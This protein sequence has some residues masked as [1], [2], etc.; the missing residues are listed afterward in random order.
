M[1][2]FCDEVAVRCPW[3]YGNKYFEYL[4]EGVTVSQEKEESWE[5]FSTPKEKLPPQPNEVE[6]IRAEPRERTPPPGRIG[7]PQSHRPALL[8]LS[9]LYP[10]VP[11]LCDAVRTET[12]AKKEPNRWLASGEADAGDTEILWLAMAL[13]FKGFPTV[14]EQKEWYKKVLLDETRAREQR[15][16]WKP[17]STGDG[18]WPLKGKSSTLFEPIERALKCCTWTHSDYE[19]IGTAIQLWDGPGQHD[20]LGKTQLDSYIHKPPLG[21]RL[22]KKTAPPVRWR[23][24]SVVKVAAMMKEHGV[25]LR[26]ALKLDVDPLTAPTSWDRIAAAEERASTAEKELQE[27]Q[28]ATAKLVD[29]HRKLKDASKKKH[30]SVLRAEE[31]AKLLQQQKEAKSALLSSLRE[32]N[33]AALALKEQRMEEKYNDKFEVQRKGLNKARERAREAEHEKQK[34]E[35]KVRRLQKKIDE[36]EEEPDS[37]VSE[38]EEDDQ[39]D[40]EETPSRAPRLEL[41]PR[42]DERGRWQ[43]EDW[44][45][46]ALRWAQQARGVAPSTVSRN[47][48]DVLSLIAPELEVPATCERQ[49]KI[50]RGEV[51][52]GGEAMAA[53]KFAKATRILSFGWD[54]S[55]KF[56]DSVFSCNAQVQHG[57]GT[58]EDICLRGLSILPEGGKSA[59][60]LAHIEKRIF[61]Y[62]RRILMLWKDEYEKSMGAGTWAMA[63]GADPENIGLHRLC[64][65]TV[66][67]TD[68][69]NGAR[70]TKRM[71]AEA[72]MESIKAKVGL[73]AWE[74]M[75]EEERSRKY[76]V[77][78]GDCWQHLRNI[79][80][81]AMAQAGDKHVK[82]A[83][84]DSLAEFSSF[85]RIE[86]EGSSVIRGIFKQ[87]H[88]GGEYCKGR[89]REFEVD[90]KRKHQ[91]SLFI[92]FERAMGSRQD[93]KFDGCVPLFWN[94][95]ICLEFLRGYISCPKSENVLDK[96]LYTIL[97]CNEF[98]A[99]LRAN[100]LWD[101]LFSRPFRWLSGRGSKLE[102]WSIF[103]MS[104]V[105]DRVESVMMEI[106]E[107]PSRLLDPELDIFQ[108][109]ADE[110]PEFKDWRTEMMATKVLAEDGHTE[111]YLFREILKEARTPKA[112][113][114]NAQATPMTLEI[115]RAQAARAVEKLHDKKIALADKLVSQDGVNSFGRNQDGHERTKKAHVSNDSVENKFAT[116]DYFMRTYRHASIHN[117]SGLVQQRT[118]HDLDRPL[119]IVSD[120]RKRKATPPSEDE[121]VP[122]GFFWNNLDDNLRRALVSMARHELAY[123]LK[124]GREERRQHDEEKLA[125]REES[126]Q[127]QLNATIEKYAAALELFD[128]WKTQGV[129]NRDQLNERLQGLTISDQLAELRR[130][131]EMRTVGCGWVQFA[132]KWSF[133]AD[134][135]SATLEQ[136]KQLLVDD[137]LPH[138]T[139]LRRQK[140]LPASAAPPQLTARLVKTL[141]TAD[142][143]AARLEAAGLFNTSN[144]LARAEAAR[145]RREAQGISDSVEVK[146]PPTA[147][148]FDTNLVGKRLEVCWPYKEN[149]GTTVKIWASGTVKRVADGLTDKRSSRAREVLPAGALLWAW[150]E[151]KEFDEPAGEKWLVLLPC[152]WNKHV[153]YAWR[154]DPC[155]LSTTGGR[156]TPPREPI[157]DPY[158][159]EEEFYE[160]W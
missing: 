120:R 17:L 43:A 90:R 149:D 80:I 104:S 32:A 37:E 107:D 65:D 134:Q 132:T 79:L 83:V 89:G 23:T 102:G 152:K 36:M 3:T 75:S 77:F 53:W 64:E 38:A 18:A 135:R 136:W 129:R 146:Q 113:S 127:R 159:T 142:A 115:I 69:C 54:E 153:Q 145:A 121:C 73:E 86:V 19:K 9:S 130:Q 14:E 84:S 13:N 68:T 143:D 98:V 46:R 12:K 39:S 16:A 42:R 41:L 99:L 56:G 71:L 35:G 156:K 94:R 154:F 108:P 125:R 8:R 6:R 112:G 105:L 58:V 44:P 85:E 40:E 24:W 110:L 81:D 140:K 109:Y 48:Q 118:A 34:A 1:C 31:R 28:R 55:T 49:N 67:M 158:A 126:L 91:T 72:V 25:A 30:R 138:E 52:L 133:D 97:R 2:R 33:A 87:F 11:S 5:L 82:D 45:V 47:I 74:A 157:S 66:L 123:A 7:L 128:A 160:D 78:R 92:P 106:E 21:S 95:L 62:S 50:I 103:K 131:V 57:D 144:L 4:C 116:G 10:I 137:V 114:G 139:S 22:N 59:E 29:T 51:T 96:S 60:V 155:E 147:P 150:D 122:G 63:G 88:H 70:C 26:R 20:G 141:G 117:V 124:V 101:I 76:K 100:S 93:L 61:A 148:P 15:E 151:D 111:Y 119:R 27:K